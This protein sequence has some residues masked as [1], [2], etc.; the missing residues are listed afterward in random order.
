MGMPWLLVALSIALGAVIAWAIRQ[1]RR[2][3]DHRVRLIAQAD[4]AHQDWAALFRRMRAAAPILAAGWSVRWTTVWGE[5]AA[6]TA[7][8]GCAVCRGTCR[9]AELDR[10]AAAHRAGP[11]GSTRDARGRFRRTAPKAGPPGGR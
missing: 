3:E 4:Q 7:S 5:I 1:R 9:L 6:S 8:P 2:F 10:L 11:L